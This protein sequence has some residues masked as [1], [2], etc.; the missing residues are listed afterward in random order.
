[1]KSFAPLLLLI[2]LTC[3]AQQKEIRIVFTADLHFGLKRCFRDKDSTSSYEVNRAMAASIRSLGKIDAIIIGGDIANRQE[4]SIQSASVSWKQF[5]NVYETLHIPLIT[6]PGNHDISNAIGYYKPMFPMIDRGA[7][8]G[9]YSI[10]HDHARLDTVH[11]R[12]KE[13]DFN[14]SKNIGGIH[15]LFIN[16]WPD[17][18]N[19]QWMEKDLRKAGKMP[20]LIFA[21]YPPEGDPKQFTGPPAK[22]PDAA[23]KSENLTPEKYNDHYEKD[24]DIF[25]RAHPNIKGYFHGHSNYQEFY[26]YKGVNGDLALPCFRVDSPLKGKL[27]VKEESLLSYQLI[28]IFPEK[29]MIEVRPYFWNRGKNPVRG[30]VFTMKL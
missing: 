16:L 24:W 25:L 10:T 17:S 20:V 2:S 30:E 23:D 14:F 3:K 6:I 22:S 7:L 1:M 13:D 5:E 9:I 15:F 8:A 18:V 29:K 27:S 19:R 28:T 4:I 26:L 21:H 12:Y 11:F